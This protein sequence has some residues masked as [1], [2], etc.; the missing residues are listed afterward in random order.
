MPIVRAEVRL[1]YLSGLPRDV[2][3]N[4]FHYL[5][6]EAND[7]AYENIAG[8]LEHF[9]NDEHSGVGLGSI[10]Y[11]LA[12]FLDRGENMA[13]VRFS[14]PQEDPAPIERVIE[15]TLGTTPATH[16]FPSEVAL[17]ISWQA[18]PAIIVPLQRR[19]GR[20]YIGPLGNG[21]VDSTPGS[22]NRPDPTV[23]ELWSAAGA[24]LTDDE[25]DF[26]RLCIFSRADD[27]G[28]EVSG[29]WVDNEWD[30]QRR[31]GQ[32]PTSR[33]WFVAG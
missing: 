27:A 13:E 26:E 3:V 1:P 17:A 21:V 5:C 22:P 9:Y 18:T 31:R 23:V 8:K 25:L 7:L 2:S 32:D 14:Q 6:D 12:P 20:T 11:Y 24:Y 33:T 28:Y 15:W 10:A 30:T 4:V 29:G 19:R 16:A